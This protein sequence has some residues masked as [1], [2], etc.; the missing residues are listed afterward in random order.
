MK[1]NPINISYNRILLKTQK[2]FD[3]L[4]FNGAMS[5]EDLVILKKQLIGAKDK[6][7]KRFFTKKPRQKLLREI[8]ESDIKKVDFDMLQNN[9]LCQIDNGYDV[10]F[11]EL[12]PFGDY[13]FVAQKKIK[14][15]DRNF[16]L[17]KVQTLTSD[18][19][20][21]KGTVEFTENNGFS[22]D[23][24]KQNTMILYGDEN[25]QHCIISIQNNDNGEPI[26]II[27]SIPS[28]DLKNAYETK[29][30]TLSNYPEDWEMIDLIKQG[31][32]DYK[33]A[34]NNLPA[35]KNISKVTK[36]GTH[37]IKYDEVS[38]YNGKTTKRYY[39]QRTNNKGEIQSYK[40]SYEITDENGKIL[41]NTDRAWKRTNNGSI[42]IIN[43]KKYETKFVK[44]VLGNIKVNIKKP[45][46]TIEYFYPEHKNKDQTEELISFLKELPADMLLDVDNCFNVKLI[47]EPE[48][49]NIIFGY[50]ETSTDREV[51]GHELGHK[52]S[53]DLKILEN[54]ELKE[55]YKKEVEFFK[56]EHPELRISLI[57]YF[58]PESTSNANGL[59]EI[60]AE[61]NTLMTSLGYDICSFDIKH[62][63]HCLS[64][65]FP[66]TVAKVADLLGYNKK[67]ETMEE[68]IN[69]QV[70]ALSNGVKKLFEL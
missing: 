20:V 63:A 17:F 48:D 46:N 42:T 33:I 11:E 43:G 27:S 1:I 38:T 30:Y 24:D 55:I 47:D 51:I 7:G 9:L 44:T 14:D 65:F 23:K 66:E 4:S 70:K 62:R 54:K 13:Q 69:F 53:K 59:A 2:S 35:G 57:D 8:R 61:T 39:S 40:Y 29:K 22:W 50:V 6:E 26:E 28:P 21:R 49:A 32:L 45:D 58:L 16:K 5:D 36:R 15:K 31:I 25:N 37:I 64:R 60:I 52:K 34:E 3:T 19:N 56:K 67:E 18:G 68:K 10:Y 41:L 12:K